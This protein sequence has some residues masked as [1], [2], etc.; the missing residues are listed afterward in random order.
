MIEALL[1]CPICG[2][3]VEPEQENGVIRYWCEECER[4]VAPVHHPP[5]EPI[6]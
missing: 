3:V 6:D 1:F 5:P 4:E 2:E